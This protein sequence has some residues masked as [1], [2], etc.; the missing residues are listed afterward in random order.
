MTSPLGLFLAAA[1]APSADPR[2]DRHGDPLPDGAVARLGTLRLRHSG[3]A[4]CVAFSPD[5]RLLASGGDD[6]LVR[7]W[8][9][10]SGRELGRSD[11]PFYLVRHLAFT[12][13]GRG[14]VAGDAS[15]MLYRLDVESCEEVWRVGDGPSTAFVLSPDGRTFVVPTGDYDASIGFRDLATGEETGR[16]DAGFTV[17]ALAV[18]PDGKTLAAA[19]D[20]GEL[21][22][23]RFDTGERLHRLKAT[24]TSRPAIAF[25]PDGKLL[26]SCGLSDHLV[27]WD[28]QTGKESHAGK[29]RLDYP[30][31]L[32]FAPDG[33]TVATGGSE[34]DRGEVRLWDVATGRQTRVLSGYPQD[35]SRLCFSPDGKRLAGVCLGEHVVRVWDRTELREVGPTDGHATAVLAA[36]LTTEPR[37][38][39]TIDADRIRVWDRRTGAC[40]EDTIR[41][42]GYSIED[43]A[44]S[45]DG[46]GALVAFKQLRRRRADSYV[47]WIDPFAH[48]VGEKMARDIAPRALALTADGS[49]FA[50]SSDLTRAIVL[51][52]SLM[53]DQRRELRPP[54][55][56]RV[57]VWEMA[58]SPD[59]RLL[60]IAPELGDLVLW[61]VAEGRIRY[62]AKL[63]EQAGQLLFSPD[64][65]TLAV[66]GET[67]VVL[68]EVASGQPRCVLRSPGAP[69]ARVAFAP[70]GRAL[71]AGGADGSL[72]VW[73][74]LTGRPS[75]PRRGHDGPVTALS[76][77]P[78]GQALI[79]GSADTTALVWDVA[80]L[81][82]P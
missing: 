2:L 41:A 75:P 68:I 51:R 79:T 25:S 1:L 76:F 27:F 56:R 20:F 35:V 3:P 12:P 9:P 55:D 49:I 42:E 45:A 66:V 81:N 73:D 53:G 26:A 22:F 38:T 69:A 4:N 28:V 57:Q 47:R 43:A 71:L 8:D 33:K 74:L 60:A 37:S 39:A 6:G 59:A 17:Q 18:S 62:T 46:R 80:R 58:F 70:S 30:R 67:E 63:R 65:R 24:R 50:E 44:F 16:F 78:D 10:A 15:G 7:L 64:G 21:A 34:L 40:L 23:W 31:T 11:G 48:K 14:L 52:G 82:L 5:G 61:N 29:D 77:A 19:G 54:D 72:R 13:D 32:A 36:S